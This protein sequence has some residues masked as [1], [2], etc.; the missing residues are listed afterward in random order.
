MDFSASG[1]QQLGKPIGYGYIQPALKSSPQIRIAA[2]LNSLYFLLQNLTRLPTTIYL[3]H[4]II[5]RAAGEA[6][7]THTSGSAAP[8]DPAVLLLRSDEL[9]LTLEIVQIA[10]PTSS[11]A[12]IDGK[13]V[14]VIN[15]VPPIIIIRASRTYIQTFK[16][17][18]QDCSPP[19][20]PHLIC[21]ARTARTARAAC[22]Y[23]RFTLYALR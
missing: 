17:P 6:S 19:P 9:D 12:T 14:E 1:L 20:P 5:R 15:F 21:T 11:T 4:I 7:L 23:A 3:T 8:N 22:T 13:V 10:H 2:Q 18:T 16:T